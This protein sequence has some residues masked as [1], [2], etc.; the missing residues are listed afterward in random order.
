MAIV[1]LP[2]GKTVKVPDGKTEKE[3]FEFLLEHLPDTDEYKEDRKKIGDQLD[4]SGWGAAIGGGLGAIGGAIAGTLA[5]PVGTVAGGV[6]GGAAG[7]AAGEGI[8]QWWTGKGDWDDVGREAAVGGVLGAVPGVAGGA[9]MALR[10][11]KPLTKAAVTAG[12]GAIG[13]GTSGAIQSGG[14]KSSTAIGAGLGAIGFGPIASKLSGV[15]QRL[16]STTLNKVVGEAGKRSVASQA[17]QSGDQYLSGALAQMRGQ[18]TGMKTTEQLLKNKAVLDLQR[19]VVVNLVKKFLPKVKSIASEEAGRKLTEAEIAAVRESLE[20]MIKGQT[21]AFIAKDALTII[22]TGAIVGA[23]RGAVRD[24][25]SRFNQGGSVKE[26]MKAKFYSNGGEAEGWAAEG[27]K[28]A[29][30]AV[31]LTGISPRTLFEFIPIVGDIL[32]A[33]EVYQ[34]LK[35]DKPNWLLI[36]AL[37]GATIIG[38]FPGLGDAAAVAIKTGARKGLKKIKG[39]KAMAK[40][41]DVDEEL[42]APFK[43]RSEDPLDARDR[44][45]VPNL[46]ERMVAEGMDSPFS[47]ARVSNSGVDNAFNENWDFLGEGRGRSAINNDI[48]AKEVERTR[49]MSADEAAGLGYGDAVNSAEAIT[50]NRG[51]AVYRSSGGGILAAARGRL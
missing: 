7:S 38:V 32:G 4:T 42:P 9:G 29:D 46:A 13:G 18:L 48:S 27:K 33:E 43:A 36:G 5:G 10:A 3:V 28:F 30:A 1:K 35:A 31:D 14:D 22:G 8:E 2:S 40:K 25:Q 41:L 50:R 21:T 44:T 51:G 26:Q 15:S 49:W 23:A 16:L 12:V 37:A 20:Q 11:A 34:E 19:S 47:N 17:K 45:S 24:D 39:G 6:G